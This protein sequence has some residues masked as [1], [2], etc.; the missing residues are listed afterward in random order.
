[1]DVILNHILPLFAIG[2]I[3]FFLGRGSGRSKVRRIKNKDRKFGS[4]LF[5]YLVVVLMDD[6]FKPLLFTA[7]EIDAARMRAAKNSEDLKSPEYAD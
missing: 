4:G 6:R 2:V 1:M 5:Y 7:H 3:S